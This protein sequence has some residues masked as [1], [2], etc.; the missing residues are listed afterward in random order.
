MRLVRLH[1][2]VVGPF[3]LC[4]HCN[5]CGVRALGPYCV[6]VYGVLQIISENGAHKSRVRIGLISTELYA[7]G[8]SATLYGLSLG[9]GRAGGAVGVQLC[10]LTEVHRG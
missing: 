10:N 2:V 4:G 3:S 9:F 6:A 8:V 5:L 1:T 7:T